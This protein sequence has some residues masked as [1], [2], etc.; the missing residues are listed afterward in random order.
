[1]GKLQLKGVIPPMI[2]PFTENEDVDYGMHVRNM[3]LWG[4]E[5]LCGYLVR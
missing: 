3:E 2:T 5:E 1:M 4:R